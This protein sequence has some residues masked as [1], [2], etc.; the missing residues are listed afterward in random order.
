LSELPP[1]VKELTGEEKKGRGAK[2]RRGG[3]WEKGEQLNI[4]TQRS[5]RKKGGGAGTGENISQK[6][7]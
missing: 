7:R 5:R 1:R 4:E 3:T 2:L 6:G